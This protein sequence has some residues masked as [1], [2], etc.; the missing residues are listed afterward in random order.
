MLQLQFE[1]FNVPCLYVA[2]QGVLSLYSSGRTTGVALDIGDG[3][4]QVIPI[5]EGYSVPHAVIRQNFGGSDLTYWLE[6]LYDHVHDFKTFWRSPARLLFNHMKERTTYVALDFDSE[7]RKA[8]NTIECNL[9]YTLPDGN[10]IG[11]AS[12]RFRC[13]ELLFQ[14][15]LNRF[16]F[17]GIHKILFDSIMKCRTDMHK[18]L[19]AN[20]VLS[21]GSTMFR[22]LA[23]RME[24]EIVKVAPWTMKVKVVA[25]PDRKYAVWIG[26]SILASVAT[27]PQMVITQEE[28]NENGPTIGHRK[29]F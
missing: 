9:S 25:P 18:D 6:H 5:H 29:C 2:L 27:F 3:V 11:L 19:Y 17:D 20:I 16:E 12:A 4:T 7:M 26:G 10:G 8:A 13:P 1:T 14:P 21:G 15:L 23:E 28:Y 24:K 22:G